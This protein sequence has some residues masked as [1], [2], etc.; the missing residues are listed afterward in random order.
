M[1]MESYKLYQY[2]N[3]PQNQK[4]LKE[5]PYQVELG[6]VSFAGATMYFG[7]TDA[8]FLVGRTNG[9]TFAVTLISKNSDEKIRQDNLKILTEQLRNIKFNSRPSSDS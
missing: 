4:V 7:D 6:G 2:I 5:K 3:S 9:R 1:F 8:S